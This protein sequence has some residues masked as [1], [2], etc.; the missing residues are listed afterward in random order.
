M[1]SV[2]ILLSAFILFIIGLLH[3]YWAFGGTWGIQAAVPTKAGTNSRLFTPGVLAT[4]VVA[5]GLVGIS[6]VLLAEGGFFTFLPTN[7]F[8]R[9]LCL[10][11][12]VIFFVRAIGDF[13]YIGF[14][15]KFKGTA[16]ANNDTWLYSPLCL[17]FSST[18][19]LAFLNSHPF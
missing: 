13:H 9:F 12:S 14:F 7:T 2:M 10:L 16:F 5:L 11:F 6:I 4:W 19:A 1:V 17:L 8:T 15:K 18:F 3:I